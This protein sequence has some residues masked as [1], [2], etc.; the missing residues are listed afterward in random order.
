MRIIGY[1]R[2]STEEQNLDLQLDALEDANCDL[3]YKDDGVSAVAQIRPGFA[4]AMAALK[5][6]DEFIIWKMDRAFR[7][8]K[9]ALDTLDKFEQQNIRFRCITEIIET[10]TPMGRCM[11]Q[12]RNVFAELE[13]NIIRERTIAGMAAARRRGARIGRPRKLS[14]KQISEIQRLRIHEP[15]MKIDEIAM[16]FGVSRKTIC[17]AIS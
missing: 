8:L 7:S 2:V 17:R 5:P 13:R 11:Y 4:Q 3:I 6:G 9:N 16:S 1:A 12:I 10:T 15:D 14:G